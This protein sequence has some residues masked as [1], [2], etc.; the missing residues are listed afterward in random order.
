MEKK[1]DPKRLLLS[2]YLTVVLEIK[3][4]ERQVIVL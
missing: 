1:V 4:I 2:V 3:A